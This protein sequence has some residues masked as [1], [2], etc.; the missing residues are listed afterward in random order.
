MNVGTEADANELQRLPMTIFAKTV[1]AILAAASLATI[2]S[3]QAFA[4]DD[5]EHHNS[6]YTSSYDQPEYTPPSYSYDRQRPVYHRSGYEHRRHY[7]S[8][9]DGE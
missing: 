6:S 8:Y 1:A 5:C 9:N 2:A 7:Y 4:W 3:S